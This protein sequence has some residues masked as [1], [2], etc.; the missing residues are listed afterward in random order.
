MRIEIGKWHLRPYADADLEALVRHANNPRVAR[1]LRDRFPHPYTEEAGRQW[2]ARVRGQQ[3]VLAFAIAGASELIGGIALEPQDDVYRRSAEIGYWLGEPFWGRGIATAAVRA[4]VAYGF[5]HLDLVRVDAGVFA[6]NPRSARVL[7]KAGF[8][9][10]GR[11]RKAI[12]KN[13]EFI[14]E[15][16][17][18]ILRE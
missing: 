1:C 11:S 3:P 17:Y 4:M 6:N 7:E 13:G 5:G 16:R 8:R 15:L 10:E 18:A 14:D 9:F 12:F 2:I